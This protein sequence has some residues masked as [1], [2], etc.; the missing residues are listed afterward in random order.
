MVCAVVDRLGQPD[1]QWRMALGAILAMTHDDDVWIEI[2]CRS[3]A[4]A[5]P[6]SVIAVRSSARSI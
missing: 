3:E 4:Q 6:F 2:P 5:A 1:A